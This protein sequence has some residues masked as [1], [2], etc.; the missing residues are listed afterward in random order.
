LIGR[1]FYNRPIAI[2]NSFVRIYLSFYSPDFLFLKGDPILRH[3][4]GRFGVLYTF[5][6]PFL[7]YGAFLLFTKGERKTKEMFLFWLLVAPIPAALTKDGSGY[8]LRVTNMLPLLT[9]LSALGL[10]QFLKLFK[11]KLKI[12]L[13][14]FLFFLFSFSTYSFLFN[15]FHVYPAKAARSFESGFKELADFQKEENFQTLLI[16]WEDY[17]PRSYFGFW[18]SSFYKNLNNFTVKKIS[19]EQS[20]FYQA[21]ENLYFSLPRTEN[22]LQVFLKDNK[23]SF[24]A[25]P[26]DLKE[27]FNSYQLFQEKPVKSI[28]YPDRTPVFYLYQISH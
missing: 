14:I 18:Q 9:Y 23:I 12:V 28:E 26:A 2:V 21:A 15:Y 13:A 19:V 27:S 7:I 8:L 17:Y 3:S 1:I 6:I 11:S 25:L 20:N 10:V 24:L 22:D 4:T 5:L 16:I